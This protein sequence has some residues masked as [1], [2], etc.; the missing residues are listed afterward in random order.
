MELSEVGL[1]KFTNLNRLETLHLPS[2]RNLGSAEPLRNFTNLTYL[3]FR[4]QVVKPHAGLNLKAIES[5]TKLQSLVLDGWVGHELES[6][7][8]HVLDY[9]SLKQVTYAVVRGQDQMDAVKQKALERGKTL[10]QR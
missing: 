7:I 3:D 6:C 9:P 1:N 5:L 8:S 10:I 2:L 4:K